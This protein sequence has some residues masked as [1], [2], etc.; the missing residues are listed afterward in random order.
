MNKSEPCGS[1]QQL[2][3]HECIALFQRGEQDAFA[4]LV[5]RHQNRVY[6][7]LLRMMGCR[8]EALELTQETMLKAFRVLPGWRPD[9]AF[10][11]WLFRVAN[12]AA[13]DRLR[14]KK[15]VKY[16][17]IEEHMDFPDPAA[18]PDEELQSAQRYRI[19]EAALRRLQED[20]RQVLLLRE[21]E[22][23]SYAE[24]GDV[25]GLREGTVKSRIARARQALLEVCKG[26]I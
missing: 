25:L 22:E 8:E 9:A 20:Y 1:W 13:M 7:F 2:Q 24:I 3:D 17:P 10:A 11:T 14:R 12:N 23:M 6:R 18:G 26:R 19:L 5:R 4:E 21:V 15:V 16:V